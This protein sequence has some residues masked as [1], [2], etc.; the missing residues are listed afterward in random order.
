MVKDL[1]LKNSI[2]KVVIKV[3]N[4]YSSFKTLKNFFK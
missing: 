4:T 1:S 2:S 3:N